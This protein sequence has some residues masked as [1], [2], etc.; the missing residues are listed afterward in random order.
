MEVREHMQTEVKYSIQGESLNIQKPRGED[1]NIQ[2]PVLV[3]EL[4]NR[5]I[6]DGK[7]DTSFSEIRRGWI[8]IHLE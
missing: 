3:G 4:M 6:P 2:S 5:L 8:N 7:G 1:G